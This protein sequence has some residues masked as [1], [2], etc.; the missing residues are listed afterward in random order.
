MAIIS[1]KGTYALNALL[2]LAKQ[3]P[4]NLLQ[5]K[6]IT[7]S[8][9]IPKNYLEQILFLLK[10]GGFIESVRGANGGYR[11]TIAPKALLVSDVLCFLEGDFY[12]AKTLD[13][14]DFVNNYLDS[15]SAEILALFDTP[16][17]TLLDK[18][19]QTNQIGTYSI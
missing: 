2:E 7:K 9:Q 11:L 3:Y 5:I 13:N 6:Q 19:N 10:N 8:T 18:W 12:K 15:I 1:T 16:L 4:D 17:S 14:S